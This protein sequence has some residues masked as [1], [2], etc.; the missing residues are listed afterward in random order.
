MKKLLLLL[1]IIA[2]AACFAQKNASYPYTGERISL[3]QNILKSTFLGPLQGV[4]KQAYQGMDIFGNYLLSCQNTGVA[5]LYDFDGKKIEKLSQFKLASYNKYNHSNVASFGIE[6]YDPADPMPLVYIS[7]CQK[8]KINNMK[9]VAYVERINPDLKSSTLVQTIFYNDTSHNFGYAL[10]WVVDRRNHYLYGYGN[11]INNSDPANRHRIVKF[12]LPSY[13][14]GQNGLLILTDKDLLENYL[15]EDYY[16]VPFNP[17]GQGLFI[18]DGMLF[19]PTGVGKTETP[20]ILYVWD[21]K[22]RCMRNVLDLTKVTHS[23]LEDCSEY[24]GTLIIQSQ[25]GLFKIKFD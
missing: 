18:H 25:A 8:K 1:T 9:D 20:S 5:T 19:M 22:N 7:Q 6:S 12:R 3:S 15:V 4:Q 23:E 17:I 16:A 2:P 24:D 21:L 10:Q 13:K 14:E 11:T